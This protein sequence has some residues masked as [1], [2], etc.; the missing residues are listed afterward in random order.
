MSQSEDQTT[1]VVGHTGE[2]APG[3]TK[4]FV[5]V[6]RGFPLEAFVVNRGGEFHAYLNR[7]R[8]VPMTMDWVENQ[9][10]TE[11]GEY[12]LCSTHGACYVPETGECV[13]GPP[14]GKFLIRVPLRIEDGMI[15]ATM[16]VDD[17][18]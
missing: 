9:F 14:R 11:D 15:V 4:K 13:E 3:T 8:H 7:C 2:I 10:L 16:P 6:Q 17:E 1:V 5:F 18:L 12:I